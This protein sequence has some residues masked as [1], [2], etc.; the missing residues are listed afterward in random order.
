MER[1]EA[2]GA[3]VEARAQHHHTRRPTVRSAQLPLHLCRTHGTLTLTLAQPSLYLPTYLP[4]DS[5]R[6]EAYP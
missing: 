3:R 4:A 5:A 6:M 1:T 2:E